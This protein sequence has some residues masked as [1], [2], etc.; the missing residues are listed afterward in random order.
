LYLLFLSLKPNLK[1]NLKMAKQ[2]QTAT[3]EPVHNLNNQDLS[4]GTGPDF[5]LSIPMLHSPFYETGI[6]IGG[7]FDEIR[8]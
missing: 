6:T 2:P 7:V 8:K 3:A 4:N 1:P 5:V